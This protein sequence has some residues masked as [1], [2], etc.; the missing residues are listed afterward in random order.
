M[1]GGQP[2]LDGRGGE[3]H[4]GGHRKR[5]AVPGA[6]RGVHRIVRFEQRLVQTGVVAAVTGE[7]VERSRIGPDAEGLALAGDQYQTDPVV[8]SAW[9]IAWWYSVSIR[10]VH[11]LC[12]C[13]RFRVSTASP[14]DTSYRIVLYSTGSS[15]RGGGQP[16]T[17]G[18]VHLLDPDDASNVIDGE[19]V[20]DAIAHLPGFET[21]HDWVKRFALL[22]D[23]TRLTLLLCIHRAGEICVTDLAA[24]AGVKDTTVSQALRLLRAH[25]VVTARREGRVVYYHLDDEAIAA[26]LDGVKESP[27]LAVGAMPPD[28]RLA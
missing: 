24:A 20:C 13:G 19:L 5:E 26:L 15:W 27:A 28:T 10:P 17:M 2:E 3:P 1:L 16:D 14:S 9:Y 18:R 8:R 25:A 23:P 12:R 21:M 7:L 6:V 22:A 4:R 11:A